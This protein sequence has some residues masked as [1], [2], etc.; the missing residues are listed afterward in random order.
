[1]NQ[2]TET[3]QR[4]L[5]PEGRFR[6][7]VIGHDIGESEGGNPQVA[8]EFAF[9]DMEGAEHRATKFL[10]FTPKTIEA[11]KIFDA[12]R[13][14][15]WDP[16]ANGHNYEVLAAKSEHAPAGGILVG[17]EA[18]ITIEHEPEQKKNDAGRLVP[19]GRTRA[20]VSWVNPVG[21][22]M[23]MKNRADTAEKVTGAADKIRS[24]MGS[25]PRPATGPARP[26]QSSAT[27]APATSGGKAPS[28]GPLPF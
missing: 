23:G 14:L 10:V 25:G 3:T 27:G 5:P 9:Q 21:G 15:G 18:D 24:L 4:A 8:I 6:G 12:L 26:S 13:A 7:K 20:V 11:G 19:T 28:K 2:Q 22:G 16:D 1:V 17:K